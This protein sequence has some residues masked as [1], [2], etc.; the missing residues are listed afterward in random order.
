MVHFG[1]ANQLRQAKQMGTR[2][3]VGV[4]RLISDIFGKA[5]MDLLLFV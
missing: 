4:S 5:N 3:V 2:L 1:H